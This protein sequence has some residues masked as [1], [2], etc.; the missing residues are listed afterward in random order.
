MQTRERQ[1]EMKRKISRESRWREEKTG[2]KERKRR[3]PSPVKINNLVLLIILSAI[4][5]NSFIH[6]NVFRETKMA[7][8]EMEIYVN[9]FKRRIKK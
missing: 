3:T 6:V 4:T 7:L 9:G 5:D 8:G 2:N 1:K